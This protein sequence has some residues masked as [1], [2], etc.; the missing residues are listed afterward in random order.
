MVLDEM[1]GGLTDTIFKVDAQG[2]CQLCALSS[3][4][5]RPIT[6]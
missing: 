5:L 2:Q 4:T 6:C 1:V 3:S